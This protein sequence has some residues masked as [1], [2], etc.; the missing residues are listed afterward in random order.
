MRTALI[1]AALL[2]ASSA[3][4]GTVGLHVGS[5]HLPD[6]GQNNVNPGIYVREGGWQVGSYLNSY[7]KRTVYVAY[8]WQ[9]GEGYELFTGGATGYRNVW[10]PTAIAPVVA[11]SK[12]LPVRFLGMQPRLTFMIPTPKTSAVAHLSVEHNF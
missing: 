1:F 6:R 3:Q 12:P 5:A 8:A 7:R 2:I 10:H 11:F 9:L 4:A